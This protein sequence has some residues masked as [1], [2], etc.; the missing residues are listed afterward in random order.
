MEDYD[1]LRLSLK[2]HP[3]SF[4]RDELSRRRILSALMLHDHPAGRRVEIAGL[5]LVRQRPDT[6]SGVI[7]MTLEDESGI[8]NIIVWPKV[9]EEYRRTVL[10]ARMVSVRGVLQKEQGVIH[11]I[12]R[13]LSDLTPD[14]MAAMM[15]RAPMP[16]HPQPSNPRRHPRN[17]EVL[18]RGRNF[19]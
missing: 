1:A 5:V 16:Q 9:F 17:V 15:A 19:H 13:R 4:I 8:A 18:P 6:A 10:G 12:A 11:V 2:A 14:L 3:V 7:F